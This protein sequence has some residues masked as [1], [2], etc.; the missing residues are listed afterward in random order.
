MM[1][2]GPGAAADTPFILMASTMLKPLVENRASDDP[3]L[4]HVS[5]RLMENKEYLRQE[6]EKLTRI[7]PQQKAA[8]TK[9]R[10]ALHAE[11]EMCWKRSPKENHA[12]LVPL[13]QQYTDLDWRCTEAPSETEC[14]E[15]K[16]TLRVMV[17]ALVSK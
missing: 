13:L 3:E 1:R 17:S 8:I 6:L 5:Q 15:F 9:L 7:S 12:A 14:N 11:I 4:D 10:K 16:E 2:I